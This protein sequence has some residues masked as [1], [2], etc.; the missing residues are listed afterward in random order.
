M[1][2]YIKVESEKESRFWWVVPVLFVLTIIVVVVVA[3][4]HEPHPCTWEWAETGQRLPDGG[5]VV[6]HVRVCR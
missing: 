6:E 4:T 2:E 1:T 5:R 3:L